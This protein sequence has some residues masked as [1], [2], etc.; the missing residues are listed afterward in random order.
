MAPEV[1]RAA[2]ALC[3]R[4]W[5]DGD[6]QALQEV[7]AHCQGRVLHLARKALRGF[8]GVHRWEQTDDIAQNVSIRLWKALHECKPATPEQLLGLL[9]QHMRWELLS[10]KRR[11]Y[12][13]EGVGAN[14][15]TNAGE[16][17]DTPD[18]QP[19]LERSWF[20]VHEL[21]EK[22]PAKEREVVDL[23]LYQGLTQPEAAALLDVAERTV[24]NRYATAKLLLKQAMPEN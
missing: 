12:G 4:R 23:L 22:L 5:Q 9:S 16:M 20:A 8:P 17:I 14:H 1:H 13:P 11:Y 18:R 24:N 10:L 2:L 15:G 6:G 19:S 3:L 21:V 7:V